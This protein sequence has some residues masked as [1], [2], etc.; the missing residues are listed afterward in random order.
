MSSRA[1][2]LSILL[3]NVHSTCNA[4]D[5]ALL[6]V[7]LSLLR[8]VFPHARFIVSANW[9]EEDALR[10]LN[11]DI[12]ASLWS[13]VGAGT[14][15]KPRWQALLLFLLW[16]YARF[17]AAVPRL[18]RLSLVPK[19]WRD[20]IQAY[21]Q[22][23]LVVAVPG[24]Q[25][26]SHGRHGWPLPLMVAAVDFAHIFHKSLY[27]L[28]QSIGPFKRGWEQSLVRSVYSKARLVYLRDH[29]S[30][31][32]AETIGL[33]KKKVLY[34]PDPA[35]DYSPANAN[36]AIE[37][38]RSYGYSTAEPS[39]GVSLIAAMPSILDQNKISRY[40]EIMTRVLTKFSQHHN[41]LIFFFNQV[42]GPSEQEDDRIGT[43]IV[44][45]RIQAKT[46]RVRIVE[47]TLSPA[48][49]KACY[50]CMDLFLASRL[51]AGIF[52]L[53]MCVPTLFVGYLHKTLGVLEALGLND[54]MVGLDNLDEDELSVKLEL[55]WFNKKERA[56]QLARLLPDLKLAIHQMSEQIAGDY[57]HGA[58]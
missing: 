12:V 54:W 3:I 14:N 20:L 28:P 31:K 23:D 32:I 40:Y 44:F 36:E 9:P 6:E 25:L 38:L 50:G 33:P 46:D 18:A 1:E 29:T 56:I 48:M 10:A 53:G 43:R 19:P 24:N 22:A 42:C 27:V 5:L 37:L 7:S 58:G 13:L 30:M 21:Q 17:I 39:M 11:V 41:L 15:R 51:H 16:I 26:F 57:S 52:S 45:E 34:A 49:L 8:K 35:F 2:Q 55:T 47:E 4:G